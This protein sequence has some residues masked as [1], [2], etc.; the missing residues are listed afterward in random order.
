MTIWRQ[1][2]LGIGALVLAAC[3]SGTGATGVDDALSDA[4]DAQIAPQDTV[5]DVAPDVTLDVQPADVPTDVVV[6]KDIVVDT[7]IDSDVPPPP[8][9][10][11]PDAQPDTAQDVVDPVDAQVDVGDTF[12]AQ[13]CA[14][15]GG[16][17]TCPPGLACW[18]Q[19]CPKCGVM[20]QG[21]C[22]PQLQSGG[23]YDYTACN[24]GACVKAN[25]MSGVAGW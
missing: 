17:G 14:G 21:F 22:L 8:D 25:P 16:S 9:I 24:G 19:P 3:G 6:P 1:S 15:F 12:V 11:A 2:L 10:V 20:A 23:C 5:A 7:W 4:G 13:N 18:N